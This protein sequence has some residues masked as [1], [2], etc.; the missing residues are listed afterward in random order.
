MPF[1]TFHEQAT[2]LY[3]R[4]KPSDTFLAK[5]PSLYNNFSFPHEKIFPVQDLTSLIVGESL[6]NI[7]LSLED[8]EISL[9]GILHLFFLF[10]LCILAKKLIYSRY[11]SNSSIGR[12]LRFWAPT[13]PK[14]SDNAL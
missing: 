1:D 14:A 5:H 6:M 8:S 9:L 13:S 7:I 4:T 11:K 12:G 10:F 2:S 3:N